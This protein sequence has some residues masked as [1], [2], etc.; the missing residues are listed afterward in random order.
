MNTDTKQFAYFHGVVAGIG[1]GVVITGLLV[2]NH[3]ILYYGLFFTIVG[4]CITILKK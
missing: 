3:N 4:A 2:N 1:L